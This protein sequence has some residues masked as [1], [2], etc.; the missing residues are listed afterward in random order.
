MYIKINRKIFVD[1]DQENALINVVVDIIKNV[2]LKNYGNLIV[3]NDLPIFYHQR[4][5]NWEGSG[6]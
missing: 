5:V 2:F 4:T 6:E 1:D 3:P